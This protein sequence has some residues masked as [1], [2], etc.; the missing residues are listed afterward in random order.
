[1]AKSKL[2]DGVRAGSCQVYLE[3][4]VSIRTP[5]V[6]GFEFQLHP[7]APEVLAGLAVHT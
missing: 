4:P 3:H 1:M 6:T 5:N 2:S 7:V